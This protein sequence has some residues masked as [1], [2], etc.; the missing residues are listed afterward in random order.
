MKMKVKSEKPDL[1][2]NVQKLKI[3]ASITSW[4]I[5]GETMKT[6]TDFILLGFKITA[7]SDCSQKIKRYFLLGRKAMTN[8]DSVLQSRNISLLTKG[9]VVKVMVLW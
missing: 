4:Q 8:L 3:M 1:K 2:L 7:H 6:V 5:D 9:H